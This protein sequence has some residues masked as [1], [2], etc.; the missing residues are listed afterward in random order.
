MWQR[1]L[2][3]PDWRF[4]AVVIPFMA[5]LQVIGPE[6]LRYQQDWIGTGE[7]WRVLLGH[8]VHVN[9]KH[10]LINCVGLVVMVGLTTPGWGLRR[11]L[12]NTIAMA[13]GI[14]LLTTLFNPEIDNYAGLSGVLYGLYFLGAISLFRRDRLIAL[15]VA[16]VIVVKVALEQ[17]GI[18][19][20]TGDLIGARVIVDSHF[21]GLLMAIAIALLQAAVKMN[22]NGKEVSN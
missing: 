4:V 20:N 16:A 7:A 19:L 2:H 1:I 11:W 22:P 6:A 8:W 12:F 10:W 9:W 5:L 21:Y 15:L 17:F 14:S 13:L 3:S 18:E